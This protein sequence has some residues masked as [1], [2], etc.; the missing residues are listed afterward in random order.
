MNPEP[1]DNEIG[2]ERWTDTRL[3]ALRGYCFRLWSWS[4]RSGA[5]NRSTNLHLIFFEV[6]KFA[7]QICRCWT[8]FIRTLT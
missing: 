2:D 4:G 7:V 8:L 6:C 5:G 1:I 3:V